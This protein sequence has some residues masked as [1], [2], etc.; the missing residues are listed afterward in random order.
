MGI[1]NSSNNKENI[2]INNSILLEE[3]KLF[4]FGVEELLVESELI[5]KL[6]NSKIKDKPLR[7][8][9]GLDPTS[10]DLHLGHTVVLVK[11]RQLQDL[12]HKVILLIGDF[13]SLIGDPS[14]RSITRPSLSREEIE[15]NSKTYFDQ[16]GLILNM[17]ET[18]IK[19][20]SEWCQKLGAEGVI[21]LASKITV[22]RMLERDD[23]TKRYKAGVSISIHE[24]LYPLVQGYDSV[25]LKSDLEVGGTDQK[26]NLLMGRELQRDFGQEPQ[27]ILTMPILEGLDGT[28]K[29]SKSK[30]NYIGLTDSPD[31]MYGKIM[32]VS[33]DLMWRYI[34]LLSLKSREEI[35][36][37]KEKSKDSVN[38][39]DIKS[40]FAFEIV[41]RFYN[42]KEAENALQEF[43][44]RFKYNKTPTNLIEKTFNGDQF[45]LI[46]LLKNSGLVASSSEGFRLIKQGGVRINGEKLVDRNAKLKKGS[47]ILQVGKRKIIKIKI[48]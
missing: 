43:E 7:I 15:E 16:A 20:N 34:F 35:E 31:E 12:G 38:P 41:E 23:F 11:L 37:I 26:F 29:M 3:L 21:N 9:L 30:N 47:Y 10:S 18:E 5:K 40:S 4:K 45:D 19:Y 2:S 44:K 42:K 6:K 24:F 32:S 33:D 46:Y 48:S 27:C 1:N 14:G 22:A 13:T 8:K 25:V 28:E 36:I 39:R 17:N